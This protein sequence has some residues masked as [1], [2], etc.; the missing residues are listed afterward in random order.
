MV[1]WRNENPLSNYSPFVQSDQ[2]IQCYELQAV[3]IYLRFIL[4]AVGKYKTET[5]SSSRAE[6][7]MKDAKWH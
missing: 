1:I 7:D 2:E 5:R 3:H 6:G 4:N